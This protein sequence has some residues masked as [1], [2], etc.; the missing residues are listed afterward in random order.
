MTGRLTTYCFALLLPALVGCQAEPQPTDA[1]ATLRDRLWRS[2]AGHPS[3]RLLF[4]RCGRTERARALDHHID[5]L[6]TGGDAA[7]VFQIVD[8]AQGYDPVKHRFDQGFGFDKIADTHFTQAADCRT[9]VIVRREQAYGFVG[10][11]A[12]SGHWPLRLED[13]I[14]EPVHGLRQGWWRP[15][16]DGPSAEHIRAQ[17]EALKD[18]QLLLTR[19][20]RTQIAPI[21]V[22]DAG[23]RTTTR[24][25]VYRVLVIEGPRASE[26]IAIQDIANP[27]GPIRDRYAVVR[28]LSLAIESGLGADPPSQPFAAP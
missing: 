11:V 2:R 12:P 8:I 14:P 25:L 23:Q 4:E 28:E 5:P 3:L 18:A 15:D 16:L 13:G 27:R 21:V 10:D 22:L 17:A 19:L 9:M 20:T 24:T 1:Q 26:L 6:M 7:V